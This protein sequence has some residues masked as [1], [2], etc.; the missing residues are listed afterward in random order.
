MTPIRLG[1]AAFRGPVDRAGFELV[2]GL[3]QRVSQASHRL[4]ITAV[5][6]PDRGHEALRDDVPDE[7]FRFPPF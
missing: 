6:L 2:F 1:F 4:W 5:T 7:C 3:W